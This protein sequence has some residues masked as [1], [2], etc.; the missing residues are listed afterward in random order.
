MNHIMEKN[1]DLFKSYCVLDIPGI[2][3]NMKKIPLG[4]DQNRP[5]SVRV[6]TPLSVRKYMYWLRKTGQ[7]NAQ[8]SQ[9]RN[10][11]FATFSR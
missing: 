1:Q 3:Q 6:N 7:E 10:T 11:N 2:L 8:E 4:Y 5:P 9:K